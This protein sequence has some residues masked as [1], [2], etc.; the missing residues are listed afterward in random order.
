MCVSKSTRVMIKNKKER[1]DK[2]GT[3]RY[4]ER[5]SKIIFITDMRHFIF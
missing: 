4:S 2:Q 5:Q 1:T 3:S